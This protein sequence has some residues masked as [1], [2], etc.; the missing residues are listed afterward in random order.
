M[1]PQVPK[2]PTCGFGPNGL[3]LAQTKVGLSYAKAHKSL[4]GLSIK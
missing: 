3:A 2:R 1:E 4:N